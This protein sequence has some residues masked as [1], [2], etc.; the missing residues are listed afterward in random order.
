MALE[1]VSTECILSYIE[2]CDSVG[3]VSTAFMSISVFQLLARG[4][5]IHENPTYMVICYASLKRVYLLTA[6][7]RRN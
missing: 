6:G 2:S 4:M 1:E 7:N 5:I 3:A